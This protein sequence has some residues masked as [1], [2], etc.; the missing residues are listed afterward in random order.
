MNRTR[1][2]V[3][4]AQAAML[5]L[6][7]IV[8][9]CGRA[10]AAEAP[11][12]NSCA[13]FRASP[14]QRIADCTEIIKNGGNK[15]KVAEAYGHRGVAHFLAKKYDLT[16]ADETTAIGLNA[17]NADDTA[18]MY[19][20]RAD[21]EKDLG[22]LD[23]AISDLGE[24]IKRQPKEANNWGLRCLYRAMQGAALQPA[25]SD[26]TEAIRLDPD[27]TDN[28]QMRAILEIKLGNFA[29]AVG[30][31]GVAL[32]REPKAARLLYLRGVAK[33]GAGDAPGAAADLAA[34][35]AKEPDIAGDFAKWGIPKL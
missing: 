2:G 6:T 31:C 5:L 12:Q 8:A 7:V 18:G 34:A 27:E 23:A 28:Y 15:A 21:A 19:S 22:R 10:V 20:I 24:A 25:L 1:I 14:E 11:S 4:S 29:A 32:E 35:K 13:N 30:D 17:S 26:C 3:A 16:I 33:R 9:L